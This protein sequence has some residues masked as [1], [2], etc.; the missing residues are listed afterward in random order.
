MIA[1]ITSIGVNLNR[2]SDEFDNLHNAV[3]KGHGNVSDLKEMIGA[4]SSQSDIVLE[5][6]NVITG[7]ASQ[8]GLL[9]MNAAIEAAH[10]G[11]A[12]RGFSV[13]A[14]EIRK[15]AEVADEQSKVIADN[16]EELRQ[17]IESAVGISGETGHSFEEIVRSVGIV[18]NLE[19]QIRG[20]L[21]EQA[22]G[23]SQVLEALGNI[24]RITE[25]V[26]TGS[27]E[28]LIGSRSIISEITGLVQVTERVKEF[29]V[30]VAASAEGVED[31]INSSAELLTTNIESVKKINGQV[32]V[33][34]IREDE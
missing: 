4:I 1:N 24:S 33:F 23:S 9:A 15:L 30:N 3:S 25:E 31:I 28:M 2:S 8:T 5:A 11:E 18:T 19:K 20:A 10:A 14:D 17:S 21:D 13:V 12:G 29:T 7:I 32:S 27:N 26:H 34:K 6:N 22:S 16:L